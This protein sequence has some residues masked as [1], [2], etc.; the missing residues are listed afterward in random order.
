MALAAI[1]CLVRG[2]FNFKAGRYAWG[3]CGALAAVILLC[4][5][6]TTHSVT[7]DLPAASH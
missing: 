6:I 2:V 5:P 7:I 1:Y 3:V 4:A